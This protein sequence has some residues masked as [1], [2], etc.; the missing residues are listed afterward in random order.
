[1]QD[2]A[3]QCGGVTFCQLQAYLGKALAKGRYDAR[4]KVACLRVGTPDDQAAFVFPSKVVTHALKVVHFEH[5]ALYYLS[6]RLAGFC[7]AT[8]PFAM[9][10]E[11]LHTKLFLELDDRFGHAWL[12][13]VQAARRISQ[14][15]VTAYGFAHEAELL[16]IHE[17]P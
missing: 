3:G 14:I 2:H 16:K 8:N 11:N 4:Q 13:C 1:M 15:E 9:A 17:S 10:L 6:H 5:D 7:K 12:G